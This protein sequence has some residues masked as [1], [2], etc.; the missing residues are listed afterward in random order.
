MNRLVLLA[1]CVLISC[2]S[3][4]EKDLVG[5]YTINECVLKDEKKSKPIITLNIKKDMTF[6]LSGDV[7][8]EG[9]WRVL[10]GM[11]RD[12]IELI[13]GK[14][15][16]EAVVFADTNYAVI[17]AFNFSNWFGKCIYIDSNIDFISFKYIRNAQNK[18]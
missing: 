18:P 9:E 17:S 10:D 2:K 5:M 8:A 15:T 11:D 6:E 3:R 16:C 4:F 7:M 14:C 12:E 1:A 13:I